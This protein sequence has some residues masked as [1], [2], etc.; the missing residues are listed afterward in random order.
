MQRKQLK[1]TLESLNLELVDIENGTGNSASIVLKAPDG[2]KNKFMISRIDDPHSDKQNI[3]QMRHFARDHSHSHD[4]PGMLEVEVLN[5]THKPPGAMDYAVMATVHEHDP[6]TKQYAQRV[7]KDRPLVNP[8]GML[9]SGAAEPVQEDPID[10]PVETI[11][12]L[13]EKEP[14]PRKTPLTLAKPVM[15]TTDEE[16]PKPKRMQMNR[17]G[18][19]EFFKLCNILNGM[20]MV[21]ISS[22]PKLAEKLTKAYGKRVAI[23]T[24]E[25]AVKATGKKL[26]KVQV[27][28]TDA[29]VIIARS[30]MA[31]MV[32]LAEPVPDDLRKLCG[33]IE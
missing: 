2:T 21:G 20:D 27:D 19:V 11:E 6:D 9:M 22:F 32:K 16:T 7:F 26:D 3:N 18:Q 29:Q 23:T 17:I 30:L 25:D 24:A 4:L 31:L 33:D 28:A 13:I 15:T 10:E 5:V 1:R 12:A 14:M 8:V